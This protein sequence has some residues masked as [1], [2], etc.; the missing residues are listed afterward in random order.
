MGKS[1]ITCYGCYGTVFMYRRLCIGAPPND[2]RGG[3]LGSLRPQFCED[4][5][6]RLLYGMKKIFPDNTY[7]DKLAKLFTE[8]LSETEGTT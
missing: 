5:S 4:C 8:S 3:P 7:F 2:G 1:P 6:K